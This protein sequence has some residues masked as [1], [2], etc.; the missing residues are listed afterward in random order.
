MFSQVSRSP[1]A[2]FMV[3]SQYC[4]SCGA[5]DRVS[6]SASGTSCGGPEN[7][8][9]T[10]KT[11]YRW[12]S[13]SATSSA[14]TFL[15]SIASAAGALKSAC[16]K[17]PVNVAPAGR[18]PTRPLTRTTG[19]LSSA[20]AV[21]PVSER[22][23]SRASGTL[24]RGAAA[25]RSRRSG[26]A[27]QSASLPSRLGDLPPEGLLPVRLLL[28]EGLGDRLVAPGDHRVPVRVGEGVQV[29]ALDR[30]DHHGAGVHRVDPPVP[31]VV[32][33]L[34]VD[35]LEA[36]VGQVGGPVARRRA[37]VGVHGARAE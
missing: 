17:S 26:H 34:D 6:H 2:A 11:E 19:L 7:V 8:R 10:L 3:I 18:V 22:I 28:A 36:G 4:L 15:R 21:Q 24:P 33:K 37:D 9:H 32:L 14:G 31:G 12:R 23:S 13:R 29:A 30:P 25:G 27:S 5:T 16:A 35:V 20:V 1:V